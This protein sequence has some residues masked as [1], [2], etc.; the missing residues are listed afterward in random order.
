MKK[1]SYIAAAAF[2]PL[3]CG[4]FYFTSLDS[5][6]HDLFLSTKPSLKQ[7]STFFILQ[8]D[9]DAENKIG[10]FP[11]NRSL[12]SE[13]SL[14]LNELEASEI[15]YDL[16][17][18]KKS[19]ESSEDSAFAKSAGLVQNVILC[20]QL[21]NAE[22]GQETTPDNILDSR[23]YFSMSHFQKDCQIPSCNIMRCPLKIFNDKAKALGFVNHITDSDGKIRQVPL[24]L[25]YND[26]Y[27]PQVMFKT[28]LEHFGNPDFEVYKNKIIIH[29]VF[30]QDKKNK[31]KGSE[32]SKNIKIP[33]SASGNLIL[34]YP[35]TSGTDSVSFN[36]VYNIIRM[37]SKLENEIIKLENLSF[38]N[39]VPDYA[40]PY[41][42][43]SEYLSYKNG[44]FNASENQ[45]E[46]YSLKKY[47]ELKNGV[48]DAVSAYI[49]GNY[50]SYVFELHKEDDLNK[51]G[52]DLDQLADS[53]NHIIDAK[54]ILK[55]KVKNS[56]CIIGKNDENENGFSNPKL[57]QTVAN[58]IYFEDF[59]SNCKWF[60]SFIMAFAISIIFSVFCTNFEKSRQFILAA[61]FADFICI[62]VNYII[63]LISSLYIGLTVPLAAVTGT[64]IFIFASYL[65]KK[66]EKSYAKKAIMKKSFL[67]DSDFSEITTASNPEIPNSSEPVRKESF[68][69][70]KNELLNV[71]ALSLEVRAF[72]KMNQISK[73]SESKEKD[74]LEYLKKYS[75]SFSHI[76]HSNNA[77]VE[78]LTLNEISAYFGLN[79]L[80]SEE[81]FAVN[82]CKAALEIKQ[83]EEEL[84]RK[85]SRKD[86]IPVFTRTGIFTSE[87]YASKIPENDREYPLISGNSLIYSK[88][89]REINKIYSTRGIIICENTKNLCGNQFLY[90]KLDTVRFSGN[91]NV[92]RIYELIS[93][94]KPLKLVSYIEQWE[95]AVNLF[96]QRQ[97]NEALVEFSEMAKTSK[98]DGTLSFYIK[99][100]NDFINNPPDISWDG[101]VNLKIN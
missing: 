45:S 60:V 73:D 84:N 13:T 95:K 99:R 72:S 2:I 68:N 97:Y 25:K 1:I 42:K 89:I 49:S 31:T 37:E 94:E 80:K 6:I 93:E 96:D 59:T 34:K 28:L 9:E 61:L 41:L 22:E 65:I 56:I 33:L 4:L 85:S 36:Y 50:M 27:Y 48:Y 43:L 40:N 11:F 14:I 79:K 83:I 39:Q 53:Y 24:V 44:I 29:S 15:L 46:E 64:F 38:F 51:N 47:L 92:F 57:L 81:N 30:N 32:K 26:H 12:F 86:F 70:K 66:H 52:I 8:I 3:I 21:E 18:S 91:E 90:R 17:F 55:S 71:S 23:F 20:S 7:N 62:F 88:Q 98:N 58:M 67:E 75:E 5:R 76:L 74:I 63:F 16:D 82:A 100:C 69:F 19:Y 54:N 87:V 77:F 101:T 10:Y 35:K 78:S